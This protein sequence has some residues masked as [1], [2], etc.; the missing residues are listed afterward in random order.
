L[1]ITKLKIFI[2]AYNNK[3]KKEQ[4]LIDARNW[5]LGNYFAFSVGCNLSDKCKYPKKPMFSNIDELDE[6]MS[7]ERLKAERE[8]THSFFSNLGKFK[9]IKKNGGS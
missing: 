4:Q 9:D 6:E 5:Q 3:F 8:R 2:K 1:D 7:E